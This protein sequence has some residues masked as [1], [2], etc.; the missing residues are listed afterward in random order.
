MICD[1]SARGQSSAR[2]FSEEE[3]RVIEQYE[4]SRRGVKLK[5]RNPMDAI[6]RLMRFRGMLKDTVEHTGKVSL[7]MLIE[8]SYRQADE[9][10]AKQ[11]EHNDD[12]PAVSLPQFRRQ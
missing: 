5:I 12:E 9:A 10:S 1:S 2:R 7:E 8:A 4:T 11:I 3:M 6:D